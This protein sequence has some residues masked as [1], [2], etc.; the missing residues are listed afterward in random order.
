MKQNSDSSDTMDCNSESENETAKVSAAAN[1]KSSPNKEI[2]R[3]NSQNEDDTPIP[4]V[5]R[6]RSLSRENSQNEDDTPIPNVPRKRSLSCDDQDLT[7]HYKTETQNL[8]TKIWE[9]ETQLE[10]MTNNSLA[11]KELL[12]ESCRSEWYYIDTSKK[13]AEEEM[14]KAQKMVSGC[15]HRRGFIGCA[16]FFSV[17]R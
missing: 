12:M 11:L 8:R 2:S 16:F 17:T 6:K 7:L 1:T 10:S 3:E 15:G 9:L 14:F 13:L 4:N 5:P